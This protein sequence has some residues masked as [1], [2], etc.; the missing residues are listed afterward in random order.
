[1]ENSTSDLKT[2][3]TRVEALEQ[4]N[5]LFKRAGLVLLLLPA[6][7]LVMG[8]AQPGRTLEA[9]NFVLTD[10][11]GTKRADL[12]VPSG[13]KEGA[14]ILRFFDS[15]GDVTAILGPNGYTIFGVGKA[16]YN[17]EKGPV[18]IPI[19]RVSLGTDGLSFSAADGKIIIVLGGID[20]PDLS[21]PPIPRLQLF[22][23]DEKERVEL[24]GQSG[25]TV[26]FRLYDETGNTRM[27][28]GLTTDGPY[29]RLS[30]SN[31]FA[32]QIGSTDLVTPSTGER[33]KS[34]A[35]SLTL[36]GKD[37]TV[38]WSAP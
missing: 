10:A 9:Q 31:G 4:Q 30:D 16:T 33:H 3:A 32:T 14:G 7:L 13:N 38:L 20:K 22:D 35:A 36:F 2:L 1:M 5:R 17:S 27:G 25:S 6:A 28:L 29:V 37:D 24:S 15:A 8:Q 26:A 18:S 23:S 34:S 12:T 11:N 19:Q 21:A